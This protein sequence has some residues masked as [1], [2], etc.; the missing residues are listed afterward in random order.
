MELVH[1][2]LLGPPSIHHPPAQ[3]HTHLSGTWS[4]SRPGSF[5]AGQF[6]AAHLSRPALVFPV[7]LLAVV[8]SCL[9]PFAHSLCLMLCHTNV[10]AA[11]STPSFNR[12][13]SSALRLAPPTPSP[14]TCPAP[15][16]T[17]RKLSSDVK[18]LWSARCW[19]SRRVL[20]TVL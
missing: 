17:T 20:L 9:V 18:Q 3:S 14:N 7:L 19:L 13:H 1:T 8:A 6:L 2:P 5:S 16:A 11:S 12:H 4:P 15:G 10:A